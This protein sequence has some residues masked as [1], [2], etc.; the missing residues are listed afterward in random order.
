MCSSSHMKYFEKYYHDLK[1]SSLELKKN[2]L[3]CFDDFIKI[4][5]FNVFEMQY[6]AQAI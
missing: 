3:M 6:D 5:F 2:A 1:T 4:N